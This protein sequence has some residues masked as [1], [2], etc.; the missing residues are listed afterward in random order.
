MKHINRALAPEGKLKDNQYSVMKQL[1]FNFF[2]SR[3]FRNRFQKAGSSTPLRFTRKNGARDF[4]ATMKLLEARKF[5]PRS[6][7]RQP[8]DVSTPFEDGLMDRC[9]NAFNAALNGQQAV[10]GKWHGRRRLGRAERLL[11]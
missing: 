1:L 4:T 5:W 7:E 3:P 11:L 2:V 9:G 8:V 10:Y 6:A